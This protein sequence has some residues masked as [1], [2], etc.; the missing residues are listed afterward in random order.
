MDKNE[1]DNELMKTFIDLLEKKMLKKYVDFPKRIS[2]L[3]KELKSLKVA[4]SAIQVSTKAGVEND[5]NNK[6]FQID[7]SYRIERISKMLAGLKRG[8]VL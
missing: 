8:V 6:A 4:Q 2:A 1:G 5:D 7:L 3:T